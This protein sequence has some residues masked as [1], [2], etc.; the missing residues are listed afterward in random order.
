MTAT[1]LME[2][3]KQ[4]INLVLDAKNEFPASITYRG[5]LPEWMDK[6]CDIR[7]SAVYMDGT[8]MYSIR[9]KVDSLIDEYEKG[10]QSDFWKK[11]NGEIE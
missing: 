1:E 10:L 6:Y 11:I 7:C 8:G 3:E 9:Y 2:E 5:K 4:Y